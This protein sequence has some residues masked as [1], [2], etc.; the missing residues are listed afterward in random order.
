MQFSETMS[1]NHLTKQEGFHENPLFSRVLALNNVSG[2]DHI[3]YSH[4]G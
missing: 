1:F 2:Y 3:G 4:Q